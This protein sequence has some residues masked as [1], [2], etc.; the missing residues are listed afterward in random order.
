MTRY[1]NTAGFGE[2][3]TITT[4]ISYFATIA[5]LGLTL[6]TVQLISQPEADEKSILG[7]LFGL[8]LLTAIGF[9]AL[10]PM[11]VW[12]FPYSEVI[13]FG[14]LISSLAFIFIALNQIFIGLFQKHL[15][16]DKAAIAEVAGRAVLF[17]AVW[18]VRKCDYACNCSRVI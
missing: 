6:V 12:L 16:M 2:Y 9:L 17:L 14:V 3:T 8:R 10:G 1:L 11:L 15:R 13:K 5:D 4:F 18:W 7:N